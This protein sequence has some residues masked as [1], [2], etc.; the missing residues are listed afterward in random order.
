MPFREI[1]FGR[2]I[3]RAPLSWLTGVKSSPS[4]SSRYGGFI[5][6]ALFVQ[7][8]RLGD[9]RLGVDGRS[10]KK[11]E[12]QTNAVDGAK[13]LEPSW[14]SQRHMNEYS[15]GVDPSF[16]C[17]LPGERIVPNRWPDY[18]EWR[19]PFNAWRRVEFK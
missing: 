16:Q 11:N 19:G 12:R 6:L 1:Q 8:G 10:G 18:D 2:E 7:R 3:A 13:R 17:W 5:V 9:D 14:D 15:N 4:V